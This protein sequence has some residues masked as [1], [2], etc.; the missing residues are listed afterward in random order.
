MFHISKFK[1]CNSKNEQN[2]TLENTKIPFFPKYETKLILEENLRVT[3]FEIGFSQSKYSYEKLANGSN[4]CTLIAIITASKCHFNHVKIEGPSQPIYGE[5]VLAL[6]NGMLLGN[7]I[8]DGLKAN[9]VISN[10]NLTIPQSLMY[11]KEY[12]RGLKEWCSELHAKPLQSSL[13]ANMNR[14]WKKWHRVCVLKKRSVMD[15]YVVLISDSRSV[16]FIFQHDTDTVSVID[17]HRHTDTKG[18]LIATVS[19]PKLKLLC[20]WFADII[21]KYYNSCPELY[22]LSYLYLKK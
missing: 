6:A 2:D 20:L 7:S 9:R 16:L 12:V 14:R 4:A 15:L 13:Y 19:R 10:F 3:W 21:Y 8:H 1:I 18:A 5:L 11:G 17:S 22:E